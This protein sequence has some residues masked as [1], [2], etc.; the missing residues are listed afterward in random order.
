RIDVSAQ[1]L[2]SLS[3]FA[4]VVQVTGGDDPNVLRDLVE[5]RV[6]PRL[7]AIEGVSQV[8]PSGGAPREVTIWIDPDRCAAFG[9]RPERVTQT[10]RKA[11]RR[12]KY[13]GGSERD[14]RRWQ[15]VL[16]GQPGGVASLGEIRLDP[17]RPVLLRH[18]ADIEVGAGRADRGFRINGKQA[19]GLTI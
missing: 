12:L 10:L 6:Q 4:M 13:L 14:G 16:D 11:G 17:T 9:V 3:R 7:A 15:V 8:W 2:T 18:V 19:T 5:D 1:D